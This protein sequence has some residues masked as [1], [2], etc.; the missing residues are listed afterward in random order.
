M[1][2]KAEFWGV[3]PRIW[4]FTMLGVALAYFAG[5]TGTSPLELSSDQLPSSKITSS[6]AANKTEKT[7]PQP[8]VSPNTN[9]TAAL[10]AIIRHLS[11][12][13]T[14]IRVSALEDLSKLKLAQQDLLPLLIACL[15]DSDPRIRADAA[16]RLGA[17]RMSAGDA[18]PALKQL[19]FTDINELVR[20]RAK[21]ALYNIR[22][23]DFGPNDF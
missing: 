3:R 20:S 1:Q 7:Q 2:R 15:N 14:N 18:V 23:Y 6:L 8:T 9:S 19:A 5:R 13:D 4:V 11:D 17:L 12:P 16:L 10:P 21:D 22:F